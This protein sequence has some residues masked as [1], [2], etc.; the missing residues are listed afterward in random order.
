MSINGVNLAFRTG[1]PASIG[2]SKK[3]PIDEPTLNFI[4]WRYKETIELLEHLE[5][6][7]YID[8]SRIN[9]A[10][11]FGAGCGGP[12]R[13]VK[14]FFDL[15][16][17]NIIALENNRKNA[18]VIINSDILPNSSVII[19]NGIE[20]LQKGERKFDLITACMFG[21]DLNIYSLFDRNRST[22]DLTVEFLKGAAKSLNENGKIIIFSDPVTIGKVKMFCKDQK[23]K[24][25]L[26]YIC[27]E[28]PGIFI[29]P[30]GIYEYGTDPGVV[31]ITEIDPDKID[32]H[33]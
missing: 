31:I 21:S 1:Y 17:N 6:L 23:A 3:E 18:E 13:A 8:R 5:G 33:I 28:P 27:I 26:D 11:D 15:E 2:F 14:S 32:T 9:S 29:S 20:Y 4:N 19:G 7:S 24:K 12:T 30:N 10:C 25:N 22:P 16:D